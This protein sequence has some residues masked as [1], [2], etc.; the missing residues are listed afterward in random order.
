MMRSIFFVFFFATST[1]IS[2]SHGQALE[3]AIAQGQGVFSTFIESSN[4]PGISVAVGLGDEVVWAEGFGLA[5]VEHNIPMT[6]TSVFRAWSISKPLTGAAA[7][8]LSERGVLDLDAPIQDYVPSFPDKGHTITLRQLLGH[9]S[10]IPHYSSGDLSNYIQYESVT[11]AL[12]KFKDRKVLFEPGTDHEYS[13][14]GYNLVGAAIESAVHKPFAEF[15]GA[16]IFGPFGMKHTRA[17]RHDAI[18][19]NRVG[20][21]SVTE[22]GGLKHAPF[23]N[24]SDLIP[25]GGF[26]STPT[27]LVR[28]GKGLLCGDLL[29]AETVDQLFT[30]MGPAKGYGGM[31]Y[32]M[33]WFV[34]E[35]QE[36][37]RGRVLFHLGGH[38][39]G[40]AMLTIWEKPR[41]VMAIMVNQTMTDSM[42]GAL[43]GL[44][45]QAAPA[46]AVL[47]TEGCS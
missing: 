28:F 27:D 12:E 30:S 2:S 3:E 40:S 21:Y 47:A 34:L 1:V 38:Y 14:F 25:G 4:T 35:P 32:G 46:F 31:G 18:V 26:L 8:L 17:D 41:M 11:A 45:E 10:G 39:G 16:E 19:P 24:N 15:M 43:F 20:F 29:K 33:G 6:P 23:T 7:A 13:T 37:G 36:S 42:I 22:T 5:N 44:R 9:R